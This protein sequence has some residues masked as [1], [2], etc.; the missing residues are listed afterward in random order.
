MLTCRFCGVAAPVRRL[1]VSRWTLFQIMLGLAGLLL[2]G[3]AVLGGA[4]AA[5]VLFVAALSALF[6]GARVLRTR[7][8]SCGRISIPGSGKTLESSPRP[9]AVL[10]SEMRVLLSERAA[11]AAWA[12]QS[13]K[14]A[15]ILA[16]VYVFLGVLFWGRSV[17]AMFLTI[18]NMKWLLMGA[19]AVIALGEHYR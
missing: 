2:L 15:L 12:R 10:A 7:C 6:T 13:A 16:A 3:Y 1:S 11:L 8:A 14:F 19:G 9:L 4:G 18:W 5:L 17:P